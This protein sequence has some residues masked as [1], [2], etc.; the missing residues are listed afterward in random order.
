MALQ[1]HL[2]TLAVDA[3]AFHAAADK[4]AVARRA[5]FIRAKEA[6][7][8]KGGDEATF[9]EAH[10]AFTALCAYATE[11][12]SPLSSMGTCL[13]A[14][15]SVGVGG[16]APP[17]SVFE[18]A[19][20]TSA[21]GYVV[22]RARSGRG[23]CK[24]CA[25]PIDAN[26]IRCGSLDA[27]TGTYTRFFHLLCWKVPGVVQR[28]V[29]DA[30]APMDVKRAL[31]GVDGVCLTGFTTLDDGERAQVAAHVGDRGA[32]TKARRVA[33][34]TTTTAAA[35]TAGGASSALSTSVK[36]A[37]PVVGADGVADALHCHTA[38]ATGV[39]PQLDGTS[40]GF[41]RGRDTLKTAIEAFGGRVTSALSKKTTLLVVGAAPGASKV[42][43]AANNPNCQLVDLDGL[44]Q[45]MR[46]APVADVPP[47][48]IASFSR[49]FG[50]N[51]KSKAG[52]SG[53]PPPA[54][55]GKR[56]LREED[57]EGGVKR[58]RVTVEVTTQAGGDVSVRVQA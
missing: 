31:A 8:D 27:A 44:C 32:W 22:E 49:G 25:A 6:H 12:S 56:V 50:G 36:F 11:A 33:T 20:P 48:A 10:A 14:L 34:A 35:E 1:Q 54:V 37:F 5:F 4:A 47:P 7:P 13:D 24:G 9:Q 51:A 23:T 21:P 46:G 43:A 17:Y 41:S 38:V 2:D 55:V 3:E 39:F 52:P 26:A 19:N 42:D 40:C 45:I 18:E 58:T 53:A 29:D 16:R 57:E 28:A 15:S 30:T